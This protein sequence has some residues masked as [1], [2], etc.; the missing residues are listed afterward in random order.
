MQRRVGGGRGRDG[1][2]DRWLYEYFIADNTKTSAGIYLRR[3]NLGQHSAIC[4]SIV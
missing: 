2:E 4:P 1:E 3:H